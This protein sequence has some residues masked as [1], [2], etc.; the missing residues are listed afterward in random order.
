LTRTESRRSAGGFKRGTRSGRRSRSFLAST[1][2]TQS[3]AF[4]SCGLCFLHCFPGSWP[5]CECSSGFLCVNATCRFCALCCLLLRRVERR[6]SRISTEIERHPTAKA[7]G[8][9]DERA[10]KSKET[11]IKSQRSSHLPFARS[12]AG[13]SGCRR[14]NIHVD[15][16]RVFGTNSR[17]KV[18]RK[19]SEWLNLSHCGGIS[20][21]E[22]ANCDGRRLRREFRHQKL[23]SIVEQLWNTKLRLLV[24]TNERIE[25]KR[26]NLREFRKAPF[27]PLKSRVVELVL[28]ANRRGIS[29]M[30]IGCGNNRMDVEREEMKRN[31][32]LFLQLA[33]SARS[34][35][36]R[37]AARRRTACSSGGRATSGGRVRGDAEPPAGPTFSFHCA[38]AKSPTTAPKR[39]KPAP[40]DREFNA[41]QMSV[42]CSEIAAVSEHQFRSQRGESANRAR[43]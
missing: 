2:S 22:A 37:P 12:S 3:V 32:K 14:A 11:Q 17:P 10:P 33:V 28:S 26:N 39:M 31:P 36:D 7:S 20:V 24:G 41:L 25:P 9:A 21:I 6:I 5:N 4:R 23:R 19:S 38:M 27:S 42:D 15:L 29:G 1:R 30:S 34:P 8:R 35:T 13:I 40:F 18:G 43:R 16:M